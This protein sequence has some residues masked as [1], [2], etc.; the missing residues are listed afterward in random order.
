MED[1]MKQDTVKTAQSFP[2]RL[3]ASMRGRVEELAKLEGVSINQY[4]A[5]ALAEKLGAVA[6]RQFFAERRR[7]ADFE[8]LRRTL[9]RE[10]GEP[11]RPGDELP[12]GYVRTKL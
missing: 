1:A 8:A 9:N 7:N 11:P 12:E 4:I 5:M 10:G 2:L 6:E 3:P